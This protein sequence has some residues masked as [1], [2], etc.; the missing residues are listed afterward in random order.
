MKV[1]DALLLAATF[2]LSLFL[3]ELT[4]QDIP[5]APSRYP[6]HSLSFNPYGKFESPLRSPVHFSEQALRSDLEAVREKTK[7]IRL[8]SAA[9]GIEQVPRLA[10]EFELDVIAA[11]WLDTRRDVNQREVDAAIKLA[12]QNR[13]VRRLI[14]GNETQLTQTVPE[15][16]L[17]EYLE[18]ARKRLR[19]PV[20]TAEPWDWWLSNPEFV[21]HVDFIALHIL[22]YWQGVPV[23]QAVDYVLDRYEEVK[24]T[25]PY[26]MV[27]IAE[28]GWP[29]EGPQRGAAEANPGNQAYFVREFVHRAETHRVPYNIVEAFDQPWKS[30]IE[31]RAGEHWG[32]MDAERREK[33]ALTGPVVVDSRWRYWA[34]SA[35]LLATLMG[36]VFL[37]RRPEVAIVGK[38]FALILLFTSTA[39]AA[40][41]AREAAYEYM[42]PGDIVFWTLV[43]AGQFLLTL[44]FI[45]DGAEIADVVGKRPLR[46]RLRP[47]DANTIRTVKKV[48][49]HL[50]CCN[51]PPAMVIATLESLARLDYPD[52]EVIVV[53]N[54]TP[55]P[56]TWEPVAARCREL[57]ERFRFFS[58]GKWPGYKAGALN[59]ALRMTDPEA[60]IIG[61]VDADYEVEP[62]WLRAAIPY[63]ENAEVAVVQ[64]PQEHRGWEASLFR[65]MENDEYSGFFRIGMVQRN[66]DNAII[67]HGTMTLVERTTLEELRGWAEWC[68]CED[69]E[70]GLRILL[71]G[72]RMLYIDHPLGHG[73]VP[74]S[75]AAYR[76]QR[77]RWAYG[78]MRIAR[79]YY[80]ELLG[81]RGG[82][83]F[84][85]RYHFIKGWL[86][87]LGDA[88]HLF[89]TV[90]ALLWSGLL[91]AYPLETD[92]PEPIFVYPAIALVLLR[93]FGTL[94][95]YAA[96]VQIGATRSLMALIAGGSLTHTIAK[97]VIQ[98]LLT[99]GKP[100]YRTPKMKHGPKVIQSLILTWEEALLA[101]LLVGAACG[102]IGEFGVVN[103]DAIVWMIG[104]LAQSLPYLASLFVALLSGSQREQNAPV[105]ETS[106]AALPIG[107]LARSS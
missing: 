56:A 45:T 102:I 96:R 29:S 47:W 58:L 18:L 38:A 51:E 65:R 82:L 84:R 88:L 14:L 91:L 6:V 46:R 71:A 3:W 101:T 100:F 93:V 9:G 55:N 19:T 74:D 68:I 4:N 42:S 25:Y 67:Q 97:G 70:L 75:Y 34:L 37:V 48:S 63:F 49:I 59:F 5:A 62:N 107:K 79:R 80:R 78:G 69:A 17:I 61:V 31:G 23:E 54:N 22:P 13:N 99:S 24:R 43:L 77:F 36:M 87:W 76:K 8:Y 33:F 11:A 44:I 104:L 85:Q 53:D 92:F 64:A 27:I 103:D 32:I 66:E 50:A 28:T 2:F 83:S 73:L 57:G 52:F 41:L 35:S 106:P 39:F 21:K 40:E 95:T 30:A 105:V 89:F 7:Q 10:R 81:M 15:G 72:K 1:Q 86:P 98:G 26:K 60:A 94:W 16:E 90:A 12:G 20:S